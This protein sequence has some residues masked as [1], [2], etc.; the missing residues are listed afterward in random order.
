MTAQP[1]PDDITGTAANTRAAPMVNPRSAT[2]TFATSGLM[3]SPRKRRPK[4]EA[5]RAKHAKRMRDRRAAVKA[6]QILVSRET[7]NSTLTSSLSLP[8]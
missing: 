6:A 4:T 7:M 8:G 5:E 3:A 2:A 1:H